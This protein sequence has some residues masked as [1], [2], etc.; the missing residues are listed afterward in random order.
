MAK[1][2]NPDRQNCG[3]CAFRREAVRRDGVISEICGHEDSDEYGAEIFRYNFC[4]LWERRQ[5]DG[6]F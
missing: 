1:I 5:K 4:S 6:K 3:T 2:T